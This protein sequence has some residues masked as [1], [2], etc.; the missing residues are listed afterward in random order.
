M[1]SNICLYVIII[2][3]K[4]IKNIILYFLLVI[5]NDFL[6]LSIYFNVIQYRELPSYSTCKFAEVTW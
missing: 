5:I 6:P 3:T 2:I 4:C 1:A